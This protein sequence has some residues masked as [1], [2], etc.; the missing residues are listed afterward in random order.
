MFELMYLKIHVWQA[1]PTTERP[2]ELEN[3]LS[4]LILY[5]ELGEERVPL[6]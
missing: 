2:L 4:V 3:W 1:A 6:L 5:S